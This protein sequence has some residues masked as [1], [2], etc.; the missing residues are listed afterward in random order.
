[1]TDRQLVARMLTEIWE[2]GDIQPPRQLLSRMTAEQA[3]ECLPDSPYSLLTNLWHTV[4]WQE[5]WLSRLR[6]G[7]AKDFTKDWYVPE[8]KEWPGLRDQFLSGF[9]EAMRIA[10]SEPMDHKMKS[11]EAAVKQLLY[12][13]IHSSYHLGQM[14]LLKRQLRLKRS[15]CKGA[16]RKTADNQE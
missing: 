5:N 11:D 7:R 16:V 8:A 13:A 10:E 3:S 14:N 15:K 2:G 1:M 6:G 12:I 4:F 9:Q